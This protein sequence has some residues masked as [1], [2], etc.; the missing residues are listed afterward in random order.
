MTFVIDGDNNITACNDATAPSS[1]ELKVSEQS[2]GTEKELATLAAKW[3]GARLIAIWN[4]L[5]GVTPVKKFTDCKKAVARIWK[6]IQSLTPPDSELVEV[7]KTATTSR[8]RP[9]KRPTSRKGNRSGPPRPSPRSNPAHRA[10][11][12]KAVILAL[13]SRADGATLAEIMAATEWQAHSVRGFVSG[14]LSK[15]LGLAVES[16]KNEAG[17]RT[18]R[19][20][21]ELCGPSA[22]SALGR[23][24]LS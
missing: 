17:E 19:I 1:A 23:S 4:N 21:K 8:P 12:K 10:T 11:G 5:P 2:F 18:Y 22:R 6:S 3:P 20:A 15:K 9:R 16:S 7:P 14:M 13:I 24:G